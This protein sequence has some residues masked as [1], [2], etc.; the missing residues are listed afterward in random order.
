MDVTASPR[1]DHGANAPT[2]RVERVNGPVVHVSGL[3]PTRLFDYVEVGDDHI[4]GEIITIDAERVRDL[5][6]SAP[7]PRR[8]G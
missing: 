7:P 1:T 8:R 6:R 5:R 3:G 2:G 4:P